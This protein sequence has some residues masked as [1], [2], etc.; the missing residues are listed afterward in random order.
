[1]IGVNAIISKLKAREGIQ[2]PI[3]VCKVAPIRYI[4]ANMSPYIIMRGEVD[5]DSPFH[6]VESS[7]GTVTPHQLYFGVYIDDLAS[8]ALVPWP[9]ISRA[10][11]G[12]HLVSRADEAYRWNNWLRS[13]KKDQD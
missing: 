3:S 6:Y 5:Y 1:M 2:T 8:I 10:S 13:E 7:P 12:Q 11:E 9:Q 4:I